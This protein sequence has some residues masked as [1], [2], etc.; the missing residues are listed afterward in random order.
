MS[1]L[2]MKVIE[3]V[4]VI[5]LAIMLISTVGGIIAEGVYKEV[6]LSFLLMVIGIAVISVIEFGVLERIEFR[7][8]RSYY[9]CS[10]VTWYLGM[11]AVVFGTGWM[12]LHAAN[13]LQY[14]VITMVVYGA[15]TSMNIKKTE[16]DAQEINELIQK[17]A[18]GSK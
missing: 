5:M 7:R 1:R 18:E 11:G 14:T 15:V 16:R 3:H 8:V 9:I 12:G 17:R 10:F 2:V 13:V 4:S 6:C